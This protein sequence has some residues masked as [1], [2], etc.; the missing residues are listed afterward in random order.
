MGQ[1][2][3]PAPQNLFGT[4]LP[5]DVLGAAVERFNDIVMV[6]EANPIDEPGLRVLFVNPAFEKITG[7]RAEEVLGRSP[8]FMQGPGTSND[9]ILRIEAA[10]RAHR[11]VRAELLNYKKDGSSFWVELEANTTASPS[12]GAEFFVFIERDITERKKR[13]AVQREQE[14]A[15]ATLFSNLPGMAYRCLNDGDW[16]M[17]FVS[18][19]CRDLTGYEPD[20]LIGNRLKSFEAIIEPEDRKAVREIVSRA[21]E[22]GEAFEITYRIR[23]RE[24]GIKWVWERGRAVPGPDGPSRAL[25]GF[26]TDIT[27]RKLLESQLLQN[28][29]L[30]SIGTLAGGIAHDLNNVFAP[31]MMAGDLLVDKVPDKDSSQLLE[32]ISASAR[33]GAELVRQI[34]LFARG[35]EGPRIAVQVSALFADIKTFLDSTLPKS[36]RVNFEIAPGVSAVSGDPVQLH[37]MLLNF[38]VNARDAMPSGG[39]LAISATPASVSASAPRP[40][41]DAV[42]GAFVRIDISDTGC[43]IP[44]IL[45]GQIFDPFFTTKGVGRGSGLGLS[46][47][48]SIVKAHCGFITFVSTEGIGTTF[49][50]FLPTA[51]SALPPAVVGKTA[52]PVATPLPRGRGENILVVDDE[53]SVRLIMRSTLENFG[54]RAVCAADGAEAVGLFRSAP[55]LFDMAIVDMQ[56][57]GLDGGKTIVTLRHMRPD[58]PIVGASGLATNQNREQAAANGVR[59]FLDKPFSVDTLIRTVHA[60]LSRAAS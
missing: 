58:L 12:T 49:S 59:H 23:P 34:L 37:Q 19:G 4:S 33:R 31:I 56:M 3:P 27:E 52:K 5:A 54:F 13:E 45:K 29:R 10:L 44:D 36:I 35:M 32:V 22:R 38:A 39:R 40:H 7:Y 11:P 9:E 25:E 1:A 53:E 26:L 48:R 17:E 14:R 50:I 20:A 51:D 43:G 16:T 8:R 47:A 30:E 6:T 42:P 41:P 2:I 46:T 55:A 28:Q 15:T 57:P 60:A 18:A 24:G 21:V